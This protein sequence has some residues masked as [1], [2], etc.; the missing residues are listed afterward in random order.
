MV[1]LAC[2]VG[3]SQL[4]VMT[5]S[6]SLFIEPVGH[7]FGWSRTLVSVGHTIG[8][9][10]TVLFSPFFGILIDR[11]GSRRIALP[12]ALVTGLAIAAFSLASGSPAQWIGLWLLYAFL[13]LAIKGTVWTA[14]VA[15]VFTV[16]QGLAL[17]I[18]LCGTAFAQ[19]ALPPLTHWLI[20]SYGW[21]MAYLWLGL[22]WGGFTLLVCWLFLYDA[23]DRHRDAAKTAAKQDAGHERPEFPGL[24]I[25]EAWRDGALWRITISTVV[26]MTLTIGLSIHQIPIL[27]EAGV[28]R[29]D[30][31]LLASLAGI[32]ALLGKLVTGVLLDRFSPNWVGGLTLAMTAFAFGLLIDGVHSP[33]LIVFAMLVNGYT[34]GTKVQIVSYL[35]ARYAGMRNFGKIFGF[36]NSAMAFGSGAGPIV[37]ALIYDLSGDYGLFLIAGTAGSIVAGVLLFTLPAYPIFARRD[38]AEPA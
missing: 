21:R 13:S 36:M 29:G 10:I 8:S 5:G 38:E 14:A 37:A 25:A 11:Y 4:S 31:A 34:Q 18:T 24:T 28:S 23:H 32:A 26:I 12:G 35:T 3:Y 6:L 7:E 20:E 30:A 17:G 1:V 15:G 16:S 19:I 2:F 27:G 33:A 9:V 22:G